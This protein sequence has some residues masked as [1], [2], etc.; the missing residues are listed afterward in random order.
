MLCDDPLFRTGIECRYC[1]AT[2]KCAALQETALNAIDT[3]TT[4]RVETVESEDLGRELGAIEYALTILNTRKSALEGEITER[5][6]QGESVPGKMLKESYGRLNW[7]VSD[8]TIE[9]MAGFYGVDL[10]KKSPITPTQAITAGVPKE[11]VEKYAARR[12]AGFKLVDDK[13]QEWLQNES[14]NE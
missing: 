3:T 7:A 6:K 8:S 12:P 10:M 9:L 13:T 1:K 14:L 4:A 2:L 11:V 5:L